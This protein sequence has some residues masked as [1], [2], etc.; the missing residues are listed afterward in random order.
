M[1]LFSSVLQSSSSS[2]DVHAFARSMNR[3]HHWYTHLREG[4]CSSSSASSS[5]LLQMLVVAAHMY[6]ICVAGPSVMAYASPPAMARRQA[7]LVSP[8][9]PSLFQIKTPLHEKTVSRAHE[10]DDRKQQQQQLKKQNSDSSN[11][12]IL[13]L[14]LMF[15]S[16]PATMLFDAAEY[17]MRE[18]TPPPPPS[19]SSSGKGEEDGNSTE[20]G[21]KRKKTFSGEEASA[22]VGDNYFHDTRLIMLPQMVGLVMLPVLL[23]PSFVI[24]GSSVVPGMSSSSSS[25]YS[26]SKMIMYTTSWP[27]L[28]ACMFCFL[29]S[30]GF[31]HWVLYNQLGLF[32]LAVVSSM[33]LAFRIFMGLWS[34][35]YSCPFAPIFLPRVVAT[36]VGVCASLLLMCIG[37]VYYAI[38][39]S[40][41]EFYMCHLWASGVVAPVVQCTVFRCILWVFGGDGSS[42]SSASSSPPV[43]SHQD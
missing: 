9:A 12:N 3:G 41:M 35:L 43:H 22:A 1:L 13:L 26:L 19:S 14:N 11:N 23:I 30:W 6:A 5:S 16:D 37:H 4:V 10:E 24:P 27:V 15:S 17:L 39:Y 36:G 29:A 40:S 32:K 28:N 18:R 33:H 42:S 38:P 21:E 20:K 8:F 34:M 2:E 31:C 7:W 25:S